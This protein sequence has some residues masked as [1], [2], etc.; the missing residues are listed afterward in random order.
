MFGSGVADPVRDEGTDTVEHLPEGHD[1]ST[2]LW[3]SHL[4]NVDRAGSL[5]TISTRTVKVN[6]VTYSKQGLDPYQ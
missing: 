4:T 6:H 5:I 3:R 1:L 2:N